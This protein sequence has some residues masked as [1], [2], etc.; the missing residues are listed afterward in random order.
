MR[1]IASALVV[2][3]AVLVLFSGCAIIDWFGWGPSPSELLMGRWLFDP[4]MTDLED[5]DGG[6]ILPFFRME[7]T[8]DEVQITNSEGVLVDRSSISDLTDSGYHY[9]ILT[10]TDH[11]EYVGNTGYVD[12]EIERNAFTFAQRTLTLHFYADETMSTIVF[13]A[14]LDSDN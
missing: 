10:R 6:G 8:E 12:Y 5:P 2:A 13:Q 9:E 14:V 7:Y 11:P 4:E 3:V 1:R